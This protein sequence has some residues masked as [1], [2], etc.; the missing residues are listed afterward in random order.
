MA[1]GTAETGGNQMN[2]TTST[3]TATPLPEAELAA[4]GYV[5]GAPDEETAKIDG[6]CLWA[7]RCDCCDRR[8]L[9]YTPYT[10][11]P[12]KHTDLVTGYRAFAVCGDCT[13][14]IEF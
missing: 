10:R 3:A 14:A 7:L 8:G 2:A 12:F 1:A 6:R 5:P 11:R 4:E 13:H 9:N